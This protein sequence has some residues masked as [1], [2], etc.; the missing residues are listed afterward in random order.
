MKCMINISSGK[1]LPEPE[2]E[3]Q[4]SYFPIETPVLG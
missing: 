2:L 1:L 4:I 3:S